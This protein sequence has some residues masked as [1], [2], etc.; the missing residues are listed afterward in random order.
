[1]L[2]RLPHDYSTTH[3]VPNGYAPNSD[4][5]RPG[6]ALLELFQVANVDSVILG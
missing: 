3:T 6:D 2:A 4:D 5:L 1:M